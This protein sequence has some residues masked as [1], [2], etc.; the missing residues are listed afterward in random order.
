MG[1]L[2]IITIHNDAM[3]SFEKD[4]KGF[5]EAILNG[6]NKAN[7]DRK[8]V[9]VGFDG[10]CNYIT[11]EYSRHADQDTLFLS[12]GNTLTAIDRWDQDFKALI[13]RMPNVAKRLLQTSKDL[14]KDASDYFKKNQKQL[15]KVS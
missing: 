10:Y 12:S 13:T 9:N 3:G 1:Y 14:L 8:Q 5:G 15:D 4:P 6:I 2:T 11:V 7:L